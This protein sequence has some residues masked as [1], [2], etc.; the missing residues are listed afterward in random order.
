LIFNFHEQKERKTARHCSNPM[1]NNIVSIRCYFGLLPTRLPANR[2]C[3]L[4]LSIRDIKRGRNRP[5]GGDLMS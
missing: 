1:K 2:D 4:K 5:P 3:L